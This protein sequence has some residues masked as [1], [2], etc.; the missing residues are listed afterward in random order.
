MSALVLAACCVAQL[1]GGPIEI[2]PIQVEGEVVKPSVFT[3]VTP[4]ASLRLHE[5]P[6][7]EVIAAAAARLAAGPARAADLVVRAR[8]QAALARARL[9][10]EL[11]AWDRASACA[12]RG[13]CP[14]P[15]DMP[16]PDYRPAL[17]ALAEAEGA[18]GADE[19]RVERLALGAALALEPGPGRDPAR[20][21]VALDELARRIERGPLAIWARFLL[22][23]QA[24]EAGD[25]TAAATWYRAGAIADPGS[26]LVP[27]MRYKSAWAHFNLGDVDQAIALFRA[28]ATAEPPSVLAREAEH[29]LVLAY[30][31]RP[32]RVGEA[33]AALAARPRASRLLLELAERLLDLEDR[34]AAQRVLV[35]LERRTFEGDEARRLD[36]VRARVHEVR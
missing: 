21:A 3:I 22:A 27:F 33:I 24:F 6:S 8:A 1:V 25:M 19:D 7:P 17:V 28:L 35:E 11:A 30:A 29:D 31:H 13:E 34:V 4:P 12:D 18:A 5:D 2:E 16:A 15:G 26:S 32:A 20:A 14:P 23:E 10:R 9:E 36:D